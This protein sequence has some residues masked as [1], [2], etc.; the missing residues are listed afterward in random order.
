MAVYQECSTFTI[1]ETR[2][3]GIGDVGWWH[4]P[5]STLG[6]CWWEPAWKAEKLESALERAA[7]A[8]ADTLV[9]EEWSV[10]VLADRRFHSF[11]PGSQPVGWRCSPWVSSI[12]H[13][14]VLSGS[15][16]PDTPSSALTPQLLST[17]SNDCWDDHRSVRLLRVE[18]Y[19][20]ALSYA[21]LKAS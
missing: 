6:S 5:A 20:H 8:A 12:S 11:H 9:Q 7:A 16:T 19:K 10:S 21:Q 2:S 17:Q 4:S 3:L 1:E 13:L 14:S 18:T 15:A